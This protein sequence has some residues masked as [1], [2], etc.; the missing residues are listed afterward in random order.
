MWGPLVITWFLTPSNY[1]Y[2]YH[3]PKRDIVVVNR[4]SYPLRGPALHQPALV[5]LTSSEHWHPSSCFFQENLQETM[6]LQL[7]NIE[8]PFI[9]S[10]GL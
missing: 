1:G 4:L 6:V 5:L 2:Y 8:V 7:Q 3:K 9:P 10:L